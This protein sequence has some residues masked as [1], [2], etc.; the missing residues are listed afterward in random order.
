MPVIV[1]HDKETYSEV[2]LTKIGAHKYAAHPSTDCLLT[3]GLV[4]GAKRIRRWRPGQPYPYRDIH[5]DDIEIQAWN[6]G[7]ERAIWN[8]VMVPEYGWPKLEL[9]QFV[10]V[11]AQ[12][13]AM[14]AGPSKLDVAGPFFRRKQ[15][16]DR[17][18]HLHMLKMCRP[19][20]DRTQLKWVE[21]R[22]NDV[23]PGEEWVLKRCHH[24][25]EALDRLHDYCDQDVW[26]EYGIAQILPPW[27][28]DQLE[29]FWECERVNDHG[30]VVDRDFALAATEYAEDEK[31]YF[32]EEIQRITDGAVRTPRQFAK[33]KEWL[34][35]RMGEAGRKICTVYE[36]GHPKFTLNADARANLLLEY[37]IAE[38]E[39]RCLMEDEAAELV[40][41]LD[42]AGKSTIAKYQGIADRAIKGLTDD[43]WRVHGLYMFAGAA[44]SGRYSSIGIQVHNLLRDVP[45]LAPKLIGAFKRRDR[46]GVQANVAAWA[47]AKNAKMKSGQKLAKPEPVHALAELIRPTITGC[48]NDTF[49]LVWSDWSSIEAR[50]LPWLANDPRA[51]DL[52]SLFRRGEDV[53]LVTASDLTGRNI[54]AEDEFERQAFGKVPVLSLGYGGGKGAFMA[55][56]KNYGVRLD[57]HTVIDIVKR[58][59][60]ANPWAADPKT[61]FWTRLEQA[62][63]RAID[64]PGTS[65]AAGRI[66]YRFDP[67]ALDGMGA[68]FA[69]LPSGRELCYPD[70]RID[71][72]RKKW[73][74]RIVDVPTITAI[75]G[76]WRPKAGEE[77]W[78]R[79][80]LWKGLLAENATQAACADLLRIAKRRCRAAGLRVC[81]D[82]HDEIM[83]ESAYP[84]RDAA[85][86]RAIMLQRPGWPGDDALPLAAEAGF[87]FRYKVKFEERKAA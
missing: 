25:P 65:Y 30:I 82:T 41:V 80:A 57:E 75:K 29:D 28:P 38:H 77:D 48:P 87:G 36:D 11:S 43:N 62:A 54:T 15:V 83:I 64:Y 37:A 61:G 12:A 52:L 86:L 21:A 2:D 72:L 33:L 56:A 79:V 69:G 39:D 19:A 46:K 17:R 24:T 76:A 27:C 14:A 53:Y 55:M 9:E 44:Q 81:A 73:G 59:R 13:R 6:S 84:E 63:M 49:D 51:E 8:H 31:L 16:K 35:P 20:D 5:K 58:W 67:E 7:F 22:G 70:A 10:C 3:S 4:E 71:V 26:T 34:E 66:N 42:M 85:R 23:A 74:G 32:A 40:E 45:K 50:G 68:L 18:G 1:H 47:T 78:P 60:A